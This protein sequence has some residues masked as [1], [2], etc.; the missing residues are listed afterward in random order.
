MQSHTRQSVQIALHNAKILSHIAQKQERAIEKAYIGTKILAPHTTL[1]LKSAQDA[2]PAFPVLVAAVY[3][4]PRN[5]LQRGDD[6]VVTP[7]DM[8]HVSVS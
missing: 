5:S 6:N 2:F 1:P 3:V 8:V 7:Q 4:L